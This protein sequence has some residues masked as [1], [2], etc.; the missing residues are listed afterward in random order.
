MV[1]VV[2]PLY[3]S[4]PSLRSLFPHDPLLTLSHHTRHSSLLIRKKE[5]KKK[6]SLQSSASSPL[7]ALQSSSLSPIPQLLFY[8]S[9]TVSATNASST[10]APCS[11]IAYT[12]N[13]NGKSLLFADFVGLYSKSKRGRR[14]I[15]VGVSSSPSIARTSLSRFMSR[16]SCSVRATRGTESVPQSDLKAK[17]RVCFVLIFELKLSFEF[18]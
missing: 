8:S 2:S 11:V 10:K 12:N 3:P 16:S 4:I 15:G 9:A 5:K 17:V 7:M 18:V 6:L 13:N 1:P 14:K